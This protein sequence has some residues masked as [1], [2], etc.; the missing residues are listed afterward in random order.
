MTHF[1]STWMTLRWT[2]LA[3]LGSVTGLASAQTNAATQSVEVRGQ[4]ASA[5]RTDLLQLC[6]EAGNDLHE[7]L[8][9]VAQDT[10]TAGLVRV[11]FEIDGSRVRAVQAQGGVPAQARAVRRVVHGLACS[12]GSAGRQTVQFNLRFVD[13]FERGV[14]RQAE[15]QNKHAVLVET[16][17]PR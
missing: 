5:I 11:Q 10:A 13:P 7:G 6:P 16:A 8:A 3:L 1:R 2:S 4:A 9:Q 17:T 14:A 12:N 15:H